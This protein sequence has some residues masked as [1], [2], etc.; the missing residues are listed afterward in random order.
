MT[1]IYR[2]RAF[3][4]RVQLS[5]EQQSAWLPKLKADVSSYPR[6]FEELVIGGPELA[7]TTGMR[8]VHVYVSF[9]NQ[10]SSS[11]LPKLLHLQGLSPY[12]VVANKHDRARIV[13]HHFKLAT[14]ENPTIRSLLQFP[15]ATQEESDFSTEPPTKRAKL[16]GQ[17]LRTLIE[18]GDLEGVKAVNYN[19][20]LRLKGTIETEC[21]KYRPKTDDVVHE[22]LW[23]KGVPGTGK[24]AY[25]K[26]TWP[27]AYWKDCCNANFEEYNGEDVVILDDFDNKRLRLM[28]VGK[29]KNLCNPAG[30]RCKVN[31]GCV[32][33]KAKIIVTSQYSLKDAFK[34]K[35]KKQFIPTNGEVV[36][37]PIED[38]PDYLAIK[39]RFKEITIKKLLYQADLQLKSKGKLRQLTPEQQ[40]A[41]DV[42]EPYDPEHNADAEAYSECNQSSYKTRSIG[43]QTEASMEEKEPEPEPSDAE[44]EVLDYDS[45]KEEKETIQG[46]QLPT[47]VEAKVM[48]KMREMRNG[49]C[50]K[51]AP[52]ATI[53][54]PRYLTL[55][56]IM[57]KERNSKCDATCLHQQIEK[58]NYIKPAIHPQYNIPDYMSSH[59]QPCQ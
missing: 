53:Y 33:V 49:T 13:K 58:Q 45:E 15:E 56:T 4:I 25:I 46:L 1:T 26:R 52:E 44:T 43:T 8:H 32:H 55:L 24:T 36:E 57:E 20:Y 47:G 21:A 19:T 11:S 48:E 35:G 59:F 41:Y 39:R 22:H 6:R 2:S 9:E 3:T 31:Y 28:T 23:I 42:F 40:A 10:H 16:S 12:W 51:D 30:D 7:P 17:E 27:N 34:H 5:K 54:D 38:D 37:D 14:K 50:W 29:L 18:A